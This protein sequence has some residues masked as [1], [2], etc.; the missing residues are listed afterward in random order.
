MVH[1]D[2]GI[3]FNIKKTWAI[4]PIERHGENENAYYSGANLKKLYTLW[5]QLYDTPEKAKLWGQ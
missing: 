1:P 3:L 5:L 2:T 4:E